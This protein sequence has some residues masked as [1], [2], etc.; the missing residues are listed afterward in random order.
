MFSQQFSRSLQSASICVICGPFLLLYNQP[1]N[2]QP[3][4]F[5]KV[6]SYPTVP[7]GLS[8]KDI[9]LPCLVRVQRGWGQ[10]YGWQENDWRTRQPML[11]IELVRTKTRFLR[12]RRL[13]VF[14]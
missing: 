8:E 13:T 6:S 12:P 2:R 5:K 3:Q 4:A 14:D 9:S 1:R 10:E 11:L 7:Q